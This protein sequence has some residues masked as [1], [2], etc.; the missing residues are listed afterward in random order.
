MFI[1]KEGRM[2]SMWHSK[3]SKLSLRKTIYYLPSLCGMQRL[4]KIWFL[5]GSVDEKEILCTKERTDIRVC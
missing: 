5:F 3:Y 2:P 4:F 1:Q